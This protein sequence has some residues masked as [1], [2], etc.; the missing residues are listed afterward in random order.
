[1]GLDVSL[2][3]EDEAQLCSIVWVYE[4]Q[5]GNLTSLVTL[6]KLSET[7]RMSYT[8]RSMLELRICATFLVS[9]FIGRQPGQDLS[10]INES[11][12]QGKRHREVS[13]I[14]LSPEAINRFHHGILFFFKDLRG[15]SVHTGP[16]KNSRK[17]RFTPFFLICFCFFPIYSYSF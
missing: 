12:G 10:Q 8:M 2:Q 13:Q 5:K 9:V 11:R 3:D 4:K 16:C 1:M 6:S 17:A 15:E 14:S 7:Q